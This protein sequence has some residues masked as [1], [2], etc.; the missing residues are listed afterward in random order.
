MPGASGD[1]RLQQP[2]ASAWIPGTPSYLPSAIQWELAWKGALLA[3][4]I[5][6]L[7]SAT[8]L[9][10]LGCFLW[11]LGAGALSVWL[12][13]RRASNAVITT[14]MGM[15]LGAL[16]GAFAYV[17]WALWSAYQLARD[18]QKFRGALMEQMNKQIAASPDPKTQEILR[19]FMNNLNT[20]AGLATFF[21]LIMFFMAIVFIVFSTAGGALG[22]SLFRRDLR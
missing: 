10:D 6:A 8:P 4:L 3:G 18:S 5:A 14:G 20:P 16:T 13:Q 7:L 22:A 9:V 19:Q 17:A 1:A 21:V 12:Y 11:L 15:R 2:A